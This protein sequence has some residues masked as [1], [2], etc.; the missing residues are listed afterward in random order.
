M[1]ATTKCVRSV[2]HFYIDVFE[3]MFFPIYKLEFF[4]QGFKQHLYTWKRL[5]ISKNDGSWSL[6]QNPGSSKLPKNDINFDISLL[7]IL[8]SP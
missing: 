7:Q 6:H 5:F 2:I 8:F 4:S 1:K 3:L